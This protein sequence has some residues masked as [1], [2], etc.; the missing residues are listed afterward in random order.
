V[1]YHGAEAFFRARAD[2]VRANRAAGIWH[3]ELLLDRFYAALAGRLTALYGSGLPAESLAVVRAVVFDS[4]R[5]ELAGPI[6]RQLEVYDGAWL[7]KIPLNN[8]LVVAARIYR[9]RL[10]LFDAVLRGS[11]G[12]LRVAVQRIAAAVRGPGA[13][14]PYAALDS[15]VRR[16]GEAGSAKRGPVTVLP[17]SRF[18]PFRGPAGTGEVY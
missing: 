11:G 14:D 18:W 4:A 6:S 7:A 12:D 10:P 9:T 1:G 13:A 3:D 17:A 16:D 15:V 8:A 5:A 2:S